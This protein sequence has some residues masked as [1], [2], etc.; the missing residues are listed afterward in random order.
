MTDASLDSIIDGLIDDL[1]P[2]G[3]LKSPWI[4]ALA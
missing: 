1:R 4:R 3:R 2:I